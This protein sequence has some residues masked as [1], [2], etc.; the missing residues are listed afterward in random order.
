MEELST[1]AEIWKTLSTQY[2]GKG[3]V[4][5][6]A[7]IDWKIRHLCQGDMTLMEYVAKLQALWTD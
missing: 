3:N 4:M 2:S 6:I 7:Q 1:A 5:L